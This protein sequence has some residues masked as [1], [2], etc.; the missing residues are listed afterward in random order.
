M[1]DCFVFLLNGFPEKKVL[2]Q[3]FFVCLFGKKD[4]AGLIF[5]GNAE[6]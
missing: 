5:G 3:T 6:R 1:R 4:E 2:N